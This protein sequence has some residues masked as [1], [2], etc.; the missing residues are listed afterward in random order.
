MR[1]AA[2]ALLVACT[3]S[4]VTPD[5]DANPGVDSGISGSGSEY[6]PCYFWPDPSPSKCAPKCSNKTLLGR[7]TFGP[8][9]EIGPGITCKTENMTGPTGM[10]GACCWQTGDRVDVVPCQ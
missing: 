6:W 5:P 1:L 10:G 8:G 7:F 9:C 3:G 4:S 2:I